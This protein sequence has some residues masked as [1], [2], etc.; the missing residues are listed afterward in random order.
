MYSPSIW[1]F[2]VNLAVL[3]SMMNLKSP[4]SVKTFTFPEYSLFTFSI[5]DST[6]LEVVDGLLVVEV[7]SDDAMLRR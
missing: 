2:R 7:E 6:M 3:T 4:M 1:N 5:S